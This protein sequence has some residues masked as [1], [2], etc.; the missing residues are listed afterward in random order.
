MTFLESLADA[1]QAPLRNVLCLLNPSTFN[2]AV[3]IPPSYSTGLSYP[4]DCGI[5]PAPVDAPVLGGQCNTLYKVT[6]NVRR[7]D[8]SIFGPIDFRNVAGPIRSVGGEW[9]P[10]FFGDQFFRVVVVA[11]NDIEPPTPGFRKFGPLTSYVD[12]GF[13]SRA[14]LVSL[15]REDGLPDN[16]GDSPGSPPP[17]Q[18]PQTGSIGP[19]NITVGGVTYNLGG[20]SVNIYAPVNIP[21]YGGLHIPI[22]VRFA[23][24]IAFPGGT[25]L[26]VYLS[27]PDLNINTRISFY[28]FDLSTEIKNLTLKVSFP[29]A[30]GGGGGEL[31]SSE[32]LIGLQ[33]LSTVSPD[34]PI[35]VIN[36]GSSA[37]NLYVPRL[38]T[39]RF[40]PPEGFPSLVAV[41]QD[42]KSL[43]QWVPVPWF[44]GAGGYTILPNVGVECAV[45]PVY[46]NI[47]NLVQ[48][49]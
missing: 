32:R 19:I 22:S 36:G 27:L 13:V 12:N 41:D 24:S 49:L 39:V 11:P 25:N 8:G 31:P 20:A 14:Y 35:T 1:L 46:A 48:P 43:D 42:V 16:C 5:P 18:P 45:T 44:Y 38:A 15:T 37:P 10:N 33:V 47:A 3:G 2:V 17:A 28:N 30:T 40:T 21:I 6:V 4:A 26:P 23:P 9:Q 7:P 34:A 29:D